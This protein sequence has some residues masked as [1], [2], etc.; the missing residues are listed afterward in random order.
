TALDPFVVAVPKAAIDVS[1]STSG[2]SADLLRQGTDGVTAPTL[3]ELYSTGNAG[4]FQF[5]MGPTTPQA[6][7]FS[8]ATS[9]TLL[10][11]YDIADTN[12][13][14]KLDGARLGKSPESDPAKVVRTPIPIQLVARTAGT[15]GKD[16]RLIIKLPDSP[17]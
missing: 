9:G 7:L 10:L 13:Q 2:A 17:A 1:T 11:E 6:E 5:L 14:L 12:A 3:F 15:A 8:D 16:I 4:T